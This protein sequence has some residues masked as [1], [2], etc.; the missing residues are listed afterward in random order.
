MDTTTQRWTIES[1]ASGVV[2]GTYAGA[3]AEEALD[4]LARDAGYA[5]HAAACAATGGDGSDLDVYPA[6]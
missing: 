3:T 5:D 6:E 1:R 4:A 2:L